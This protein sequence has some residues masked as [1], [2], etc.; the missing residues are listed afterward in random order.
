VRYMRPRPLVNRPSVSIVIPCYD[1]GK[2]LP[3]CLDSVLSQRDVEMQVV[4]VDD[5]STDDSRMVAQALA[6]RDRRVELIAHGRNMGH[7]ATY[8]EGLA[9]V[10]G[11]Y[12]VLLS[13]DD[14]L[15]PGALARAAAV[16]EAHPNVGFVYGHPIA[17]SGFDPPEPRSSNVRSWTVWSGHEWLASCCR[18]ARNV[19]HCPEVVMRTTVQREI[20]A[21]R[22]D[23]PH[24]GD[25]EM[26]LRA[27]RTADVARVNGVDQAYYRLHP[28]SMQRTTYSRYLVDLDA[29]LSA[30]DAALSTN[31]GLSPPHPRELR[32]AAARAVARGALRYALRAY[33]EGTPDETMVNEYIEYALMVSPSADSLRVWRGLRRAQRRSAH[34]PHVPQSVWR[35]V[36]VIADK[37]RWRW[38]RLSGL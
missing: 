36:H 30:I 27:A 26:W 37:T 29:R 14:L 11:E 22:A 33:D 38:W 18:R 31:V 20:G 19:I 32:E 1:Y 2:Y 16:L 10:E 5:A 9:A 13:A 23:L 8:N 4:I 34:V 24:S 17:F 25:F 7:I 21:Y 6:K 12:L 15:T 28:R 3:A 35:G